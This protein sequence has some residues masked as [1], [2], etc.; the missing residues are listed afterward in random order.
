[1][2]SN[3]K[4]SMQA[5]KELRQRSGAGVLACRRAL[6]QSGGDPEAALEVLARNARE[7]AARRAERWTGEGYVG[8][9]V[10]HTGRL[11]AMVELGCETDF[12]ARTEEFRTLARQLAEQVAALPQGGG[13]TADTSNTPT[14]VALLAQPWIREPATTIGQLVQ[15]A[16]ARFCEAISVRQIARFDLNDAP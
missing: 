15:A 6:E 16:S 10:H 1:M 8:V 13:G 12:V 3:Q 7:E 5:L 11:G 9:Y 14:G 4:V 2:S